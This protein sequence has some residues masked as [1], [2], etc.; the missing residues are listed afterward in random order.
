MNEVSTQ[1]DVQTNE[2]IQG[3]RRYKSTL[4]TLATGLIFLRIGL[5][6]ALITPHIYATLP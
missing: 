2:K 6:T 1:D 4:I 5:I 3:T